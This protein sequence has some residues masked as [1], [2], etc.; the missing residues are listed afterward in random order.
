MSDDPNADERP[1]TGSGS[2]GAN[3]APM[4]LRAEAPRV[5]RLSRKVL[6]GLGVIAVIGVGGALIFALQGRHNSGAPTEL[7]LSLIH[8]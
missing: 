4:R 8:I 6:A 3:D 2:V 5:T 1:L 7:F